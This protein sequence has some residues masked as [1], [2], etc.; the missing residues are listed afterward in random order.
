MV[1][2][3]EAI[4]SKGVLHSDTE[5]RNMLWDLSCQR[6]VVVDF[7]RSTIQKPLS[8][9]STNSGKKR[10][11]MDDHFSKELQNVKT[12]FEGNAESLL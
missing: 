8:S 3:L 2:A 4:H 11:L 1:D 7:E 6:V 10:K 9:V 12:V 5:S